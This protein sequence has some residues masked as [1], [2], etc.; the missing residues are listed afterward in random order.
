MTDADEQR[1]ERLERLR[2]GVDAW[3]GAHGADERQAAMV[4]T[5]FLMAA[6]DGTIKTTEYDELIGTITR[7]TGDRLGLSRIRIIASQLTELLQIEGW[8][9]RVTAVAQALDT[10]QAR[11]AAFMLAAGVSF[12]DGEVQDEEVQLFGMLADGFGIPIPEAEVL[13]KDVH[14]SLF[15]ATGEMTEPVLLLKKVRGH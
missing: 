12:I 1:G 10:M 15:D 14:R 3:F 13:L 4:E 9:A 2:A 7:V 8:N 11:R 5:A 6:A